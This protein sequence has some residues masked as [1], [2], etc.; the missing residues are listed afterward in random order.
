MFYIFLVVVVAV[1]VTVCCG[2][3]PTIWDVASTTHRQ[4][5]CAS[6]RSWY[7]LKPNEHVNMFA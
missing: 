6:S 7:R 1:V 4:K 2:L 5:Y 3:K